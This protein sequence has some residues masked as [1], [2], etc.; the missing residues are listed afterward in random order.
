MVIVPPLMSMQSH[1]SP[2]TSPLAHSRKQ[3]GDI[4][5]FILAA[6]DNV[7]E[8]DH[9]VIRERLYFRF[10]YLGYVRLVS[11]VVPDVSKR[12]GFFKRLVQSAVNILL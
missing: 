6:F 12:N 4:Y 5:R 3:C 8:R 1:V 10:L 2:S 11:G 7:E 9:F